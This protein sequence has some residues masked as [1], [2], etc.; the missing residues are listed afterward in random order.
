MSQNNSESAQCGLEIIFYPKLVFLMICMHVCTFVVIE[1]SWINLH[2]ATHSLYLLF[3]FVL[4]LFPLFSGS[5][6]IRAELASTCRHLYSGMFQ[7]YHNNEVNS[8]EDFWMWLTSLCLWNLSS[9][10][11]S[12]LALESTDLWPRKSVYF[13]LISYLQNHRYTKLCYVHCCKTETN[14]FGQI[15]FN[16][17]QENSNDEGLYQSRMREL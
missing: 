11:N 8:N 16:S 13:S 7:F 6:G 15:A 4:F 12:R 9:P 3:G 5:R 2:A 17:T 1:D 10:L 14:S